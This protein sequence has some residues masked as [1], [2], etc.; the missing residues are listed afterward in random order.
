MTPETRKRAEAIIRKGMASYVE[1]AKLASVS[2]QAMRQLAVRAGI[3]PVKARENYLT[4][5]WRIK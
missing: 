3:D 4:K 5:I 2:R 1:L